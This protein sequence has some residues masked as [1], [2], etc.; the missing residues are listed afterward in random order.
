MRSWQCS[1]CKR[2]YTET[3]RLLEAPI[4]SG[5]GAHRSKKMTERDEYQAALDSLGLADDDPLRSA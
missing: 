1:I 5:G 3:V 4:C 2:K